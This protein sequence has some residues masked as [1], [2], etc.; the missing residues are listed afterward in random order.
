[1]AE[2]GEAEEILIYYSNGGEL[3][4]PRRGGDPHTGE[5]FADLG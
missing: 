1:M 2:L 3:D 4:P 5:F